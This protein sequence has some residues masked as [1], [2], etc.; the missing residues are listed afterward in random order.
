M[1]YFIT[2]GAHVKIGHALNVTS[3]F[4]DLQIGNA[5]PLSIVGTIEGGRQSERR[6]HNVIPNRVRGEWFGQSALLFEV[7]AAL[8][9]A[10]A[11]DRVLAM[12]VREEARKVAEAPN[13]D[14]AKLDVEWAAKVQTLFTLASLVVGQSELARR[15]RIGDQ[16]VRLIING[17]SKPGPLVWLRFQAEFGS[18]VEIRDGLNA[19]IVRGEEIAA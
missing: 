9:E 13:Y 12:I 5:L 18:L 19:L 7:L 11:T 14:W 2:D 1:I 10:D 15:V 8:G 17:K 4:R 6:L 16:M 3:R